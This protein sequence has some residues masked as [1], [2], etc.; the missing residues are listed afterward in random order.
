ML[1]I[2]LYC[3]ALEIVYTLNTVPEPDFEIKQTFR[4][5]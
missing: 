1:E 2:V 4:V 5:L 3:K